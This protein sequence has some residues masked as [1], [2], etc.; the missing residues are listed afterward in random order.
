MKAAVAATTGIKRQKKF[1]IKSV[2]HRFKSSEVNLTQ[3]NTTM[4]MIPV[5]ASTDK[6]DFIF[7]P[8]RRK[9]LT[10]DVI[11]TKKDLFKL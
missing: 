10:T 4:T 7:F 11:L 6:K 3:I 1:V 2:S 5:V 9:K 8:F